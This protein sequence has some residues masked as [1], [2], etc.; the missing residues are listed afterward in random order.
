MIHEDQTGFILCRSIFNNI[1]LANTIINY[2]E[3][4]G[5]NGAI[6]ALDQEKAYDK[7]CHNYL[8]KTL[9]C[10]RIPNTFINTVK[11]LY[12]N[13]FTHIAINGIISKQFKVTRGIHQGDPLSCALFNLAIEPL[14]CS[15]RN[16]CTIKGYQIPGLPEKIIVNL[17]TDDTTLFLSKEDNLDHIYEILDTWC[18]AS[19]AKFNPGKT[20][21]LP[22]GTHTYRTRLQNTQT[23]S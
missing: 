12:K 17:Y 20:E 19:G 13:A 21:I 11:E 1:R 15:I 3:L 8:W 23:K 4:T 7:I 22:I 2:A 16:D 10:F 14:A 18:K 9:A 5:T 6:I